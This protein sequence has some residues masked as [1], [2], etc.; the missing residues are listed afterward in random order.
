MADEPVPYERVYSETS[1]WD[2]VKRF[3]LAAG[4]EVV[5]KALVL[6]YTLGEPEVPA[7]AK[8]TITVAPVAVSSRTKCSWSATT[9]AR[10][11]RSSSGV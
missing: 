6:Y 11:T 1:F 4:R 5:E 8:T 3:A 9:I 2:K 10:S 7:W